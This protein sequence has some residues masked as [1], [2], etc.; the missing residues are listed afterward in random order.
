MDTVTDPQAD[1]IA[2]IATGNLE[3]LGHIFKRDAFMAGAGVQ[4]LVATTA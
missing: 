1:E 4:D 3:Q 2:R